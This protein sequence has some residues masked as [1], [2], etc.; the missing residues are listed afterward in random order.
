MA[1]DQP[2]NRRVRSLDGECELL[3]TNGVAPADL[4][5]R[6]RQGAEAGLRPW[7]PAFAHGDLQID[8]VFV[9][10]DEVTGIID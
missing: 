10:G 2:R 4:V 7:P 6:N 1:C 5:T 8:H 9:D 3:V